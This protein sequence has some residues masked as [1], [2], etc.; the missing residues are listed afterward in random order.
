MGAFAK[1]RCGL[2]E[3]EQQEARGVRCRVMPSMTA[4]TAFHRWYATGWARMVVPGGA[5]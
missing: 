2:A 4:V 3:Q 5:S 1:S